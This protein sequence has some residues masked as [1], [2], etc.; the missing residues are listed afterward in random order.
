MHT[1]TYIHTKTHTYIHAYIYTYIHTKTHTYTH[2]Y[3]YTYIHTH[4]HTYIHICIH[5]CIHIYI[6]T[7]IHTYIQ[8]PTIFS[9]LYEPHANIYHGTLSLSL[10]LERTNELVRCNE[11]FLKQIRSQGEKVGQIL[12]K[13]FLSQMQ[14]VF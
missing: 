2:A 3:I 5:I 6:H 11:P 7:Y 9:A 12:N 4:I 13:S 10:S 8:V 1:Y 14:V